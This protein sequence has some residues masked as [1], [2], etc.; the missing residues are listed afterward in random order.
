M[1]LEESVDLH[2]GSVAEHAADLPG[3]ELA[4]AVAFDGESFKSGASRIRSQ[5]AAF[6]ASMR[7]ALVL[8]FSDTFA[9]VAMCFVIGFAL[10]VFA[11]PLNAGATP[12]PDAH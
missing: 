4:G 2:S 6:S 5:P 7:E 10:A 1:L 11:K 12:P 3:R 8:T 9:A